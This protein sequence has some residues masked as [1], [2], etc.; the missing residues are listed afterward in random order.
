MYFLHVKPTS[1]FKL[2]FCIIP[3]VVLVIWA[4][5]YFMV[6]AAMPEADIAGQ[7]ESGLSDTLS[8]INANNTLDNIGT[9]R[10]NNYQM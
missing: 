1:V 10:K 3:C 9:D 4:I 6:D 8:N 5:F 2:V 7:M